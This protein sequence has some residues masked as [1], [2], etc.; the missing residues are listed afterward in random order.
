[1]VGPGSM[2]WAVKVPLAIAPFYVYPLFLMQALCFALFA[3][4]FNLLI[5]YVGLLSFGHALFFGWASYVSAHAAK[6]WGLP[7]EL[8]ILAGTA[9]GAGLGIVVGALALPANGR[10]P[11]VM[12]AVGL[13]ISS[14]GAPWQL[15][16]G[17]GLL[18]SLGQS[19]ELRLDVTLRTLE[20]IR[21]AGHSPQFESPESWWEAVSGFLSGVN[22]G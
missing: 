12:I 14:L 18:L 10:S 19:G 15:Y 20:V 1:M 2:R 6:V 22:A 13:F 3:C 5:G 11:L 17:H 7:P 16:V 4:A 8:A 21:D 9:A